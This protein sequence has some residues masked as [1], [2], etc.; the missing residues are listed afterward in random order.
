MKPIFTKIT[1]GIL[2]FFTA[3][4]FAGLA[5]N[6]TTSTSNNIN[7]QS[8][9]QQ[10][11]A[12]ELI[13]L[14]EQA[15]STNG[16]REMVGQVASVDS[17]YVDE[18]QNKDKSNPKEVVDE[19]V[20]KAHVEENTY[21]VIKVVDG[22][23][24]SI[25]LNGTATTLRL[26][27]INTPETV[28]PRKPV[29]CF[30]VEASNKAKEMLSGKYITIETDPTQDMYD[31]YGRLL[32]YVYLPDG[33]NFNKFMVAEGY[34]YEYTY[35]VPYIY[36]SEF[37]QAQQEARVQK[38]GLWADGVCDTQTTSSQIKITPAVQSD[39][40]TNTTSE[41]TTP[42]PVSSNYECSYNAY[43]CTDFATH[44]EAQTVY[45]ACGGVYNDIHR[46][47]QDKDGQACESLP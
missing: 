34:A 43:N 40:Q 45:E 6:A 30:G 36:Q 27:G 5:D 14:A 37:K 17:L 9:A 26:I 29:E 28:D 20:P 42:T 15:V 39:A 13:V 21:S 18:Q 3:L 1:I 11:Y 22:D 23:T 41:T 10:Q 7:K 38:I 12:D 44:V 16:E 46:L 31:K 19:V 4:F 32:A 8:G 25:D 33:T 24:L 47:D 2:G 35:N